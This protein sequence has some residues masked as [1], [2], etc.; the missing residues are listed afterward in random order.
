MTSQLPVL[1]MLLAIDPFIDTVPGQ[2]VVA[3]TMIHKVKK[4]C[5]E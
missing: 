4:K 3:L 1:C 5:R 2:F